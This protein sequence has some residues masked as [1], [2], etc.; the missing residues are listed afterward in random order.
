[1]VVP[2]LPIALL[3]L[4]GPGRTAAIWEFWEATPL[5]EAVTMSPR[6]TL[7]ASKFNLLTKQSQPAHTIFPLQSGWMGWWGWLT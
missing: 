2:W 1:M 3:P 7:V 4:A 6:M 5:A